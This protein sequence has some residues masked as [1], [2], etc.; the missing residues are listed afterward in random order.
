[1]AYPK[2]KYRKH[3]TGGFF[4]STLVGTE[5]AEKE[6]GSTWTDDP[7]AHGF[8]VVPN[9]GTTDASGRVGFGPV[10]S[11]PGVTKAKVGG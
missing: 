11:V 7:H 10:G 3:P 9:G 2:W 4:Q 8:K 6:L 5:A 1:M